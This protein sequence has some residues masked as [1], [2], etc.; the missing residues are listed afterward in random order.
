MVGAATGATCTGLPNG[1]PAAPG[2]EPGIDPTNAVVRRAVFHVA[3]PARTERSGEPAGGRPAAW[4]RGGGIRRA[5]T[6]HR[7]AARIC[8]NRHDAH[9]SCSFCESGR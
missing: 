1:L 9:F 6:A 3:A 5:G 7:A 8:T 4:C 2:L